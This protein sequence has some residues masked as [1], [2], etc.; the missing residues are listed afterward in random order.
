[1]K[2]LLKWLPCLIFAACS[3]TFVAC[4]DDDDDKN[5]NATSS[6]DNTIWEYIEPE[7][8]FVSR[9]TFLPDKTATMMEIDSYYE[10]DTETDTYSFIW[11]QSGNSVTLTSTESKGDNMQGTII[12]SQL[13]LKWKEDRDLYGIFHKIK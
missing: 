11:S 12:D 10:H 8:D 4:S 3:C 9:L 2:N 5:N 1:M 7:E 13:I 6:L